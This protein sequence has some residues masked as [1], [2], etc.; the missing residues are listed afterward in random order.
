[1]AGPLIRMFAVFLSIMSYLKAYVISQGSGDPE[2]IFYLPY[3]FLP[4][5]FLPNRSRKSVFA[6]GDLAF[7]KAICEME[8]SFERISKAMGILGAEYKGEVRKGEHS[9]K[10]YVLPKIPVQVIYYEA[11]DE[12]PCD[13]K[14]KFDGGAGR[15]FDFETLAFL[16]GVSFMSW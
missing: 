7:S 12:F 1:M 13:I 3:H 10:F 8:N 14:V 5:Y 11:D 6:G 9:W 15:F 4:N 16:Y 2:N